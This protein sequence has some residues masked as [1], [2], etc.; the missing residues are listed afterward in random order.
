MPQRYRSSDASPLPLCDC[1]GKH[2]PLAIAPSTTESVSNG[3]FHEYESD[4]SPTTGAIGV[5]CCPLESSVLFMLRGVSSRIVGRHN[6]ARSSGNLRNT[7]ELPGNPKTL[8]TLGNLGKFGKV[9]GFETAF[10]ADDQGSIPFTRSGLTSP[11]NLLRLRPFSLLVP[12]LPSARP[13]A[14]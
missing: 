8:K 7:P 14:D 3:H 6:V 4:L 12:R 10:P 11:E 2:K 5:G 13:C 9:N 1:T